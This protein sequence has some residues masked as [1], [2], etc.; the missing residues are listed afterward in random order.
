MFV[1]KHLPGRYD[2]PFVA[3]MNITSANTGIVRSS[4]DEN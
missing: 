1:A 4:F 2:V 3:G